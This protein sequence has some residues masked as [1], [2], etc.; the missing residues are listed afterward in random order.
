MV[1]PPI[2]PSPSAARPRVSVALT[3]YNHQTYIRECLES[4]LTQAVDFPYEVIIGDDCSIDSTR[5]IIQEYQARYP[6]IIKL[7]FP[8]VNQGHVGNPLFV[9][10]IRMA[11]GQYIAT[12]DGDDYWTS[13]T[14]LQQQVDFMDKR[15]DYTCSFHNVVIRDERKIGDIKLSTRFRGDAKS[16]YSVKEILARPMIPTSAAMFR[17]EVIELLPSWLENAHIADWVIHV[18]CA[19]QGRVGY[20]D[21]VLSVYR[22]HSGGVWTRLV[23]AEKHAMLSEAIRDINRATHFRYAKR[24][25]ARIAAH[26]LRAAKFYYTSGNSLRASDQFLRYLAARYSPTWGRPWKVWLSE[27]LDAWSAW[28]RTDRGR[29]RKRRLARRHS[30]GH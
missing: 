29:S 3:A 8:A 10:I 16:D 27:G 28:G 11:R 19:Q 4:V 18:L 30:A 13:P 12:L 23:R 17:R 20:F 1:D 24:L 15:P 14:K 7:H 6:E 9:Q 5:S 22:W 2:S 21:S 25:T 26:R